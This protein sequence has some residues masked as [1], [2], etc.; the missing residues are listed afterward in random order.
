MK[1]PKKKLT[2]ADL[3]AAQAKLKRDYE[4][5][6]EY[7]KWAQRKSRWVE[8][9]TAKAEALADELAEFKQRVQQ[10][11][12]ALFGELCALY[13]QPLAAQPSLSNLDGSMKVVFDRQDK[14]ALD[15]TA[16]VGVAKIKEWMDANLRG[17][18]KEAHAILEKILTKKKD[19]FDALLLLKLK[20]LVINGTITSPEFIDGVRLIE[21]SA[22]VVGT[23]EYVRFYKANADGRLEN[24]SLQFSAM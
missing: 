14:L 2:A 6:V 1:K 8:A 11:G 5:S 13:E 18:N 15:E 12:N 3:E 16:Q 4:L 20:Q 19:E 9:T 10:Q 21:Q 17:S 24:I 7:E 22:K 23:G